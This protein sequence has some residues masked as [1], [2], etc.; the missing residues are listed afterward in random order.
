MRCLQQ[1]TDI[2]PLSLSGYGKLNVNGLCS[3]ES[4]CL[5][6]ASQG[7][8][9]HFSYQYSYGPSPTTKPHIWYAGNILYSMW[10][11]PS[12]DSKDS[13]LCRK[14]RST[15]K[16]SL[17]KTIYFNIEQSNWNTTK[18]SAA[19]SHALLTDAQNTTFP[20]VLINTSIFFWP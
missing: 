1:S 5:N 13:K 4:S 9:M 12:G 14:K 8:Q 11:C 18:V 3:D 2:F 7:H 15:K 6:S 16:K 17:L 20:Y 10:K 19:E